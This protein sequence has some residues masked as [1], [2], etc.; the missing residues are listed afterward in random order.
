MHRPFEACPDQGQP[1]GQRSRRK[2]LQA[3]DILTTVA[4]TT[5]KPE[6]FKTR[7]HLRLSTEVTEHPIFFVEHLKILTSLGR[8]S[9]TGKLEQTIFQ[10]AETK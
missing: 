7:G 5:A 6:L 2:P 4:P 10:Q 1:L 8:A 9:A 3:G